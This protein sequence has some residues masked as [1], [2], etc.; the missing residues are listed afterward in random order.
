MELATPGRVAAQPGPTPTRAGRMLAARCCGSSTPT[1]VQIR[2]GQPSR[3]EI[4]TKGAPG[5]EPGALL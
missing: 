2:P 5:L 3:L 4:G 1:G